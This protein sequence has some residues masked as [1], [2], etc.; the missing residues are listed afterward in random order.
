MWKKQDQGGGSFPE[1]S[2]PLCFRAGVWAAVPDLL[3]PNLGGVSPR[4]VNFHKPCFCFC[5]KLCSGDSAPCLVPCPSAF[6]LEEQAAAQALWAVMRRVTGQRSQRL[7]AW[8]RRDSLPRHREQPSEKG[9]GSDPCSKGEV[10]A[11]SLLLCAVA[12]LMV[13]RSLL[14]LLCLPAEAVGRI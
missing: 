13:S 11:P 10:T 8:P 1:F 2:R 5:C 9:G 3:N 14:G 6:C 12:R 4:K 7:A